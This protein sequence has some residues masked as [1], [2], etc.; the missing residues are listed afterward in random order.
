M[1]R[2]MTLKAQTIEALNGCFDLETKEMKHETHAY[3]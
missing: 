3:K 2:T 1:P